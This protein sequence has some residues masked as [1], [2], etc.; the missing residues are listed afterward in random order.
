MVY[1]E[2]LYL[3]SV[4]GQI[5]ELKRVVVAYQNEV[6]MDET[7]D[8]ALG[9]TLGRGHIAAMQHLFIKVT[10]RNAPFTQKLFAAIVLF[11]S[12]R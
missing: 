10:L 12:P 3:R 5:P 11:N 2:P 9:Q 4:Q 7:L 1:V 8:G 6:V